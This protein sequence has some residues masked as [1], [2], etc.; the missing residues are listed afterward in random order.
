MVQMIPINFDIK[1]REN[2]QVQFRNLNVS[3]S[4]MNCKIKHANYN[5]ILV[6]A[7]PRTISC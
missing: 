1:V 4:V 6:A 7:F 5:F 2:F 3:M